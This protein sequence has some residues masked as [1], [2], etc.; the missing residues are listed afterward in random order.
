MSSAFNL[1]ETNSIEMKNLHWLMVTQGLQ[2]NMLHAR[3]EIQKRREKF[4][5]DGDQ[6]DK[7]VIDAYKGDIR[8]H[9]ALLKLIRA[10]IFTEEEPSHVPDV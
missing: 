8:T 7:H 4:A 2:R 9:Q 3:V 6:R 10:T 5:V 1:E